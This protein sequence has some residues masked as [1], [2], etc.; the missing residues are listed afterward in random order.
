MYYVNTKRK[1]KDEQILN[2]LRPYV[3]EWF[4]RNFKRLTLPQKFSIPLI[5]KKKNILVTAPTGIGKTLSAFLAILDELFKL[6]ERNKLENMVYCIY[7]SPL[8]ALD[9]DINR[10]LLVPLKEIP[11]IAKE[12]FNKQLQEVRIGVR[13]GDTLPSERQRQLRKPPH[14]LITTPETIAILLGTRKF[15]ENLRKVRWVIVDEIHELANCKRGVHLSLSLERLQN[16]VG[17]KFVRIGLGACLKYDQFLWTDKGAFKIGEL[18]ET[19]FKNSKSIIKLEDGSE[20]VDVSDKDIYVFSY[21]KRKLE[22]RKLLKV[23]RIPA[24]HLLAIVKT[25]SGKEVHLTLNDKVLVLNEGKP[26]WKYVMELRKGEKIAVAMQVDLKNSISFPDILEASLDNLNGIRVVWDFE[27]YRKLMKRQAKKSKIAIRSLLRKLGLNE[28]LFEHKFSTISLHDFIKISSFLKIN[29]KEEILRY[30][31]CGRREINSIKI[32]STISKRLLYAV[33][34]LMA[35]GHNNGSCIRLV[36]KD[37]E[38]VDRLRDII[39]REFGLR[40]EVKLRKTKFGKY[41]EVVI[42]S[43]A[44]SKVLNL[45]GVRIGKK[46]EKVSIPAFLLSLPNDYLLQLVCGFVDG[47]GSVIYNAKERKLRVY[48]HTTSKELFNQIRYILQ[49]C[50][51]ACSKEVRPRKGAWKTLY[52]IRVFRNKD[53]LNI[54]S[55]TIKGTLYTKLKLG[56]RPGTFIPIGAFL[57]EIKEKFNLSFKELDNLTE[58]YTFDIIKRGYA[59]TSTANKILANLASKGIPFNGQNVG[60]EEVSKIEFYKFKEKYVYD[61]TVEGAHNF[62]AEGIIVHNTL[63]PLEEAAKFLVGLSNG[64]SRNCYIID[65]RF[66]KPIDIKVLVPSKHLIFES[67]D[68]IN[69]KMYSLLHKLISKHKTT[70]VFTNTRS[71]AERVHFHLKKM[72][73]SKYL[74]GTTGVHHSSIS[75]DIRFEV[76]EKMKKGRLKCAISSTSLELGIDIGYIDLVC[77]I[78]SPKSV[79]RLVQRVGRSGHKLHEISKGRIICLDRDDLIECL[80]MAKKCYEY[81]LDR[82]SMPKNCLDVLAQHLLG[83]A[84]EKKWNVFEAFNLVKQAYPFKD[85]SFEIFE[86]VLNYLA[87][88]Y[89]TLEDYSVYGKIWY[90]ANNQMFGRRGKYARVIYTLNIGTIPDEIKIKVKDLNGKFIGFIEE[91]FLERLSKGDIFVLGGKTYEFV[92]ARKNVAYV[93]PVKERRPTIPSWFSEQL[94]LNFDLAIE[95]AKFRNRI[96]K[97][98]E[99]KKKSEVIK[100]LQKKYLA[101]RDVAEIIYDYL[102][103]E[104]KFLKKFGIR[105]YPSDKVILVENVVEEDTQNIV[106]HTLFG[107]RVNDTLSRAYGYVLMK[108]VGRSIGIAINDNGFILSIPFEIENYKPSTWISIRRLKRKKELVSPKEIVKLISSKNLEKILKK[109]ILNTELMKRKFRHNAV[110]SLMVLRNYKGHEIRVEKQQMNAE[111]LIKVVKKIEKFPILEE[112]FREILEDFMDV[113][114]S[115]KILQE[116]EKGKIKFE[117]LPEANVPSPFA[118]NLFV[119][120]ESDVVLMEDRK[121]LLLKLHKKIIEKLA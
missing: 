97:L 28:K 43:V 39:W 68:N 107:R 18:V 111:R 3:K 91:G 95:I 67:A 60:Y 2:L 90:D 57:S 92:K 56:T 40:K 70:L 35:D 61:L 104:L 106:F 19:F 96:L 63:E 84:I 72:F 25:K 105:N 1:A 89:H 36:N 29:W 50:G 120:N 77:Q 87:G 6:A 116:I 82:F 34:L 9:N 69:R 65:A 21:N 114:N 54:A 12:R 37:K 52:L 81:W 27:K 11:E 64:R 44:L 4:K 24:P 30:K 75:R 59:S 85:L 93:L 113:E 119:I 74:D 8:R 13:T 121:K 80:V 115:K 41:F 33:G 32:P 78:G 101:N 55:N 7:I 42:K 71:G 10:N 17:K 62:V 5:K 94:P 98:I 117:F 22:R 16:L 45:L 112:T 49:R 48:I 51:I 15:K 76:E 26:E 100:Y 103:L 58:S 46:Y 109:A 31:I 66:I 110:R 108:K 53:A 38:I 86:K 118:H 14:I 83:M 20:G 73:P 79:S 88:N 99:K 47:D 23:W 102:L